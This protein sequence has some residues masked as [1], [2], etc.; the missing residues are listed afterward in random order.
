MLL[1][2]EP[3]DGAPSL[4]RLVQRDV[5]KS[6]DDEALAR[7]SLGLREGGAET[8]AHAMT[9]WGGAAP[10]RRLG[11]ALGASEWSAE[12]LEEMTTRLKAIGE[13]RRMRV[14][15]RRHG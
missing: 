3:S 5:S 11:G 7:S 10:A 15:R 9:Q 4:T 12:E 2:G 14:P 8:L 13:T 1:L 6:M